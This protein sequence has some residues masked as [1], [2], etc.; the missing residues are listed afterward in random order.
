M[1]AIDE[2][3]NKTGYAAD[4]TTEITDYYWLLKM[5]ENPNKVFYRVPYIIYPNEYR[6]EAAT[7]DQAI[8]AA[9]DHVRKETIEP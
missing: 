1:A 7:P 2:I 5:K 8:R 4:L 6:Q 9:L 3:R